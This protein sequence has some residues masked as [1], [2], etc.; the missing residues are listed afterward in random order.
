MFR[1]NK[2][3]GLRYSPGRSVP[4]IPEAPV[5]RKVLDQSGR[6]GDPGTPGHRTATKKVGFRG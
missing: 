4:T 1:H 5:Q 6:K 3:A 2:I